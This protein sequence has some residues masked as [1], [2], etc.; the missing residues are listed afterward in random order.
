MKFGYLALALVITVVILIIAF[1][2]IATMGMFSVFFKS[3]NM[4]FTLPIFFV[5]ALGMLAGVFYT[6]FFQKLFQDETP[7]DDDE[8][9]D[10]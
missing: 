10:F 6:V 8:D 1:Q 4:S 2:N 3:V 9:G 5:S 7:E